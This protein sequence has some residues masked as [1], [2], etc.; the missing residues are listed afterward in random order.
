LINLPN[1]QFTNNSNPSYQEG[2]R[3]MSEIGLYDEDKNLLV[4]SKFNSPQIRRDVQRI[5]IKLDF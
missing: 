2:N 3:Y 4:L 1:N 5:T